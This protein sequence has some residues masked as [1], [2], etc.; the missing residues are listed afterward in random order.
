MSVIETISDIGTIVTLIGFVAITPSLLL[1]SANISNP[2]FQMLEVGMTAIKA[3][4][5]LLIPAGLL[6]FIFF[7]ADG[8][9]Q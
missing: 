4:I 7:A 5:M 2:D 1:M 9:S 6:G 3:T 8:L